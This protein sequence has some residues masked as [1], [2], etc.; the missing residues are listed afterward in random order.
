M[1]IF[2]MYYG[3]VRHYIKLASSVGGDMYFDLWAL[4]F[5]NMT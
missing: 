5:C 3:C 2:V 4:Q 1:M